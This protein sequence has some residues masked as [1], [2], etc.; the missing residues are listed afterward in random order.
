MNSPTVWSLLSRRRAGLVVPVL[1][2]CL[3]LVLAGCNHGISTPRVVYLDGAGWFGSSRAVS[4][5]LRT[6]GYRGAFETFTW[7]TFLGAPADHFVAARSAIPAAR[8]ARRLTTLRRANPKGKIYLIGLSAG[9]AVVVKGLEALPDG[10]EVDQVVLLSSSV[11]ARHDLADA[12]KHV[13]GRLYATCSLGDLI[14][15]AMGVS[16]DGKVGRAGGRA[17]F[18]LPKRHTPAIREQYAK[19]V[20]LPWRP[21]YVAFGWNGG[22]VRVTRAEFI[23]RVIA[24][25][26]LS[27]QPY[28]LDRP[29]VALEPSPPPAASADLPATTTESTSGP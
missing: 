5:G 27:D 23:Q 14:L 25:R 4:S 2:S 7:T 29:L 21:G 12:L 6:A 16:S 1:A 19:M 22:H 18:V 15:A 11:S 28:P 9:T 8:L 17:G 26:I 10:I 3:G 13:R 20:N 24:P